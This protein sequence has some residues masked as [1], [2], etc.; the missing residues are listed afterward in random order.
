M[1]QLSQSILHIDDH[2]GLARALDKEISSVRNYNFFNAQDGDEALAI[3][4]QN[5]EISLV[6]LD[7][8]LKDKNGLDLIPYLR[9]ENPSLKI[10]VY[11]TYTEVV[12]IEDSKKLGVQGYVSKDL[13]LKELL[14][15][16]DLILD[17][18][19]YFPQKIELDSDE[20]LYF[21][22]YKS[23]T[24]KEKEIFAYTIQL[25]DSKEIADL[26]GKSEKTIN[27]HKS[28]IFEKFYV[29]NTLGLLR[30]AKILGML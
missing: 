19:E 26:L 9:K 11:S 8:D 5:K 17:G 22:I 21:K 20:D 3:L 15:A 6:I 1:E 18:K 28:I 24:P 23:L 7:L 30:C 27:N 2:L 29:N 12:Y 13:D 16:I 14:T 4:K 10:L 25:K